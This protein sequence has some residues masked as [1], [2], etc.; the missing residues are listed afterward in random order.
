MRALSVDVH[1]TDDVQWLD[2][3]WVPAEPARQRVG[4]FPTISARTGAPYCVIRWKEN[5]RVRKRIAPMPTSV[6]IAPRM[7]TEIGMG[8]AAW[9]A[10]RPMISET[11][12]TMPAVADAMPTRR[13]SATDAYSQTWPYVPNATLA[14]RWTRT[15]I[16]RICQ[17]DG[18]QSARH[19]ET[20][21]ETGDEPGDVGHRDDESVDERKR[22]IGAYPSRVL[23]QCAPPRSF[24]TVLSVRFLPLHGVPQNGAQCPATPCPERERAF[25][26]VVRQFPK[27]SPAMRGL[28]LD[29]CNGGADSEHPLSAVAAELGRTAYASSVRDLAGRGTFA[30]WAPSRP[31]SR[32]TRSCASH[33]QLL[34]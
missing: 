2:R 9:K 13:A 6:N 27:P 8:W 3:G 34:S 12:M 11:T 24:V 15:M 23:C 18:H 31:S 16:G 28:R 10:S 20:V 26:L 29:D 14:I 7:T 30:A 32:G 22:D 5:T 4:P 33:N 21:H 25:P 1:E 17:N 19:P